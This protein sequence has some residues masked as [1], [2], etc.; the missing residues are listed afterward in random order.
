[1]GGERLLAAGRKY[2]HTV[3]SSFTVTDEDLV[4]FELDVVHP[5][6]EALQQP[7]PRA[8]EQGANERYRTVQ[9]AEQ[10]ADLVAG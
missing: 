10:L 8:E 6:L 5:E 2:R 1:M 9:L 7:Q 3:L 4:S